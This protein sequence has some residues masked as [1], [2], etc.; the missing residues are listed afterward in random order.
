MR[1]RPPPQCPEGDGFFFARRTATEKSKSE[2]N[3]ARLKLL[4]IA[5]AFDERGNYLYH[6]ACIC[7]SFSLY[8]DTVSAY[9]RGRLSSSRDTVTG[10][11]TYLPGGKQAGYKPV[12]YRR[13]F[14]CGGF[15]GEAGRP[16]AR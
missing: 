12:E 7:K 15:R 2:W 14:D 9:H 5:H 6:R 1:L 10:I 11:T 8:S 3:L 4:L 16:P 13:G